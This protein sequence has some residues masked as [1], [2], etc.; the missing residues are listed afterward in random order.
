MSQ[1]RTHGTSLSSEYD[2][3]VFLSLII[4]HSFSLPNWRKYSRNSSGV[5]HQHY[6]LTL[7]EEFRQQTADTGLGY[8][9]LMGFL[10]AV[11]R[12]PL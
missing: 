6:L 1:S 10:F 8:S 2:L 11:L 3:R 12:R 5:R 7:A 9:E 4:R